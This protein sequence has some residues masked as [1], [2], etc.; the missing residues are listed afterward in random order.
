MTVRE[1]S[2]AGVLCSPE[3]EFVA[4]RTI[5]FYPSKSMRDMDVDAFKNMCREMVSVLPPS[6]VAVEFRDKT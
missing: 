6:V 4:E 2:K 1:A 3:S 5:N